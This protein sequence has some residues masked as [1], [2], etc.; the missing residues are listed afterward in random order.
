MYE[1]SLY[2]IFCEAKTLLDRFASED[3][4]VIR[5]EITEN[6]ELITSM[7]TALQQKGKNNG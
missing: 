3:L 6:G 5:V 1:V 2:S 7:E 4:N